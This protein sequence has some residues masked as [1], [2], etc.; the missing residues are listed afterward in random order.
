MID[1]LIAVKILTDNQNVLTDNRQRV[2]CTFSP[3]LV[4]KCQFVC[5]ILHYCASTIVY[6]Q[7]KMRKI[8]VFCT[9]LTI[10]D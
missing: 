10:N 5:P 3:D 2:L 7:F 1:R 8:S 6:I 4:Y 9:L